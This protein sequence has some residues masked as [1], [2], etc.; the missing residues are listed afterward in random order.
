MIE[1]KT[2]RLV[3]V[4]LEIGG[5]LGNGSQRQVIA[6]RK[7]GYHVGR[8]FQIQDDLLDIT[9]GKRFGKKIG[10]DIVGG[11]KTFLL[12]EALKK[13]R[14]EDRVVLQRV[15]SRE[16]AGGKDVRAVKGIYEKCGA[17]D[18]ARRE[19]RQHVAAAQRALSALPHNNATDMLHW[20]AGALQDRRH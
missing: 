8:A 17:V 13:A 9:G 15:M 20:L 10:G 3:S 1:L 6:L 19:V 14:K 16:K 2:G 7:Y 11:K 4:T 18:S 12:L 5:L